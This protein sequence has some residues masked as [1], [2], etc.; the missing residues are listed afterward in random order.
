MSFANFSNSNNT[1]SSARKPRLASSNS[2]FLLFEQLITVPP[3]RVFETE[4]I[5]LLDLPYFSLN[6]ANVFDLVR[7]RPQEEGSEAFVERREFEVESIGVMMQD[8][9]L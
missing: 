9:E 8:E 1:S 3:K 6:F 5:A 2:R 7:S 4:S